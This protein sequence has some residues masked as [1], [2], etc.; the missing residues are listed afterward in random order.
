M[1]LSIA[2]E[3]CGHTF[4]EEIVESARCRRDERL[5]A[6]LAQEAV[7]LG[8][9]GSRHTADY[10]QRHIERFRSR[11]G[12]DPAGF[13]TPGRPGVCGRLLH[14]VRTGL[15]RLLKYQH[16][17]LVFRQ[18]TVNRQLAYELDF[19]HEERRWTETALE[20]RLLDLERRLAAVEGGAAGGAES[21]P[22]EPG[23]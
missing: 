13:S 12:I 9:K 7:L 4:G 1:R 8:L 11:T 6:A 17:W 23:T 21:D 20:Q 3:D 22:G 16:E 15:W 5:E 10:L 14:L 18:N 2:G 19:E